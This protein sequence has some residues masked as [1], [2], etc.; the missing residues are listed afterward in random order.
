MLLHNP[1]IEPDLPGGAL[2]LR[3]ADPT[4]LATEADPIVADGAI[5]YLH[6]TTTT[7]PRRRQLPARPIPFVIV[8]FGCVQKAVG[9]VSRRWAHPILRRVP[10]LPRRFYEL[11]K[12]QCPTYFTIAWDSGN[13]AKIFPP[14]LGEPA[15][16]TTG[17]ETGTEKIEREKIN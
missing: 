11:A 4:F 15:R 5:V 3:A 13:V 12:V 1:T 9:S 8:S 2:I 6:S 17:M 7:T 16:M 10:F 14:A